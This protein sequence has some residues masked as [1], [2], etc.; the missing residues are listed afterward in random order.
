MQK[1]RVRLT[2]LGQELVE[3]SRAR[4]ATAHSLIVR[5]QPAAARGPAERGRL[6]PPGGR[7][8]E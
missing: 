5:R 2:E 6:D 1:P 7:I 4:G 3:E 8:G